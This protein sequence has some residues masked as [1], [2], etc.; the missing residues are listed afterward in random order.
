MLCF[1]HSLY[2]KFDICWLT[3]LLPTINAKSKLNSLIYS[4]CLHN[5]NKF[6]SA[7]ERLLVPVPSGTHNMKLTHTKVTKKY[8]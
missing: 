2:N 1:F 3:A 5:A 6:Y 7:V 4:H 8:E